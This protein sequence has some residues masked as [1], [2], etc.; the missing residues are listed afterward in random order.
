[1]AT[2]ITHFPRIRPRAEFSDILKVEERFATG[3]TGGRA[4]SA[5]DSSTER[6]NGWFDRLMVQSGT[7][8]SP[9]VLLMLCVV[10]A[11]G[12]GG[13]AFVVRENLLLTGIAAVCGACVPVGAAML[14]RSRRQSRIL[15]QMP[16]MVGEMARAARTGR[17]LEQ[18]VEVVAADTDGPLG[19]ELKLCRRKMQMGLAV[20]AAFA[21]LPE[22]TGVVSLSIFTMA[23]T[24][25]QQTGGDLV[26]VLDR[27]ARTIRD[28][29]GFLGRLKAQ[30][31]ASRATAVLMLVLPPFILGFFGFR[32]PEYFDKLTLNDWGFLTLIVAGALQITGTVWVLRILR[33]TRRT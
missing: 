9:T 5:T 33:S 15:K 28:R 12:L 18:C 29:I 31:I 21:D 24:V 32:D 13:A 17:S 27:L 1:M 19:D 4:A 14:M 16:D 23:L 22:R 7:D 10:A 8:T 25:H 11:V 26:S 20:D 3:A 6:L 2:D 30:T